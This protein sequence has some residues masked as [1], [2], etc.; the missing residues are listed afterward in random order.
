MSTAGAAGKADEVPIAALLAI[1][2][3]TRSVLSQQ[4]YV[5]LEGA[6]HRL[7]ACEDASRKF[8]VS[9]SERTRLA[10]LLKVFED[11]VKEQNL[12]IDAL[13]RQLHNP[14]SEKLTDA[15]RQ[16]LG[17]PERQK[18]PAS[19][20]PP[21]ATSP[22][23]E[24]SP[25][26][27]QESK[28][29]RKGGGR[30]PAPENLPVRIQVI[31]VPE[32]Q[33]EGMEVIRWE[34]T[35][36]IG[37]DPRRTYLLRIVRA[38]YG[39][40]Q[41]T[42]PPIVAPLPP[43]VIPRAGVTVGFIVHILMSRFVDHLPYYRQVQIDERSGVSIGRNTRCRYAMHAA[44]LLLTIYEQ[45]KELVR[46]GVY[47]HIDEAFTKLLDATRPGKARDAY[48]WGFYAPYEQAMVMEFS[49]S[50]SADVLRGF[51][52]EDWSGVAH[53]DGALMYPAAFKD[54]PGIIHIECMN[55]FRR[56]VLAAV[57]V[58]QKEALP[59][60]QDIIELYAIEAEATERNLTPTQRGLL[61]HAKAKPVLKRLQRKLL[62]LSK[63]EK[64]G[65]KPL[66]GKLGTAVNYGVSRWEHL[67]FYAKVDK[68][69]VSTDQNP[70]ER[71]WRPQKV[72][73]RNYLFI[74]SPKAGWY[75][76]VIYTIVSTCRLVGVE[77]EEYLMWV[78]PKL[79]AA[80]TQSAQ[81]L[82][83]HD[84]KKLKDAE[85]EAARQKPPPRSHPVCNARPPGG[86]WRSRKSHRKRDGI[87]LAA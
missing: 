84:F 42:R 25:A 60:L 6:I 80:T 59:L 13:Q 44:V 51:L 55:H 83:P 70:I 43:Q 21:A 78:L 3:L 28:K 49:T 82:L 33:R 5:L 79:A 39:S 66:L 81:G 75:S 11:T 38:V 18:A 72:G 54:R 63:R 73:L 19:T 64:Q 9:E 10:G 52:G 85:A 65:G 23:P 32:D 48:V 47:L 20:Q 46:S 15:K 67:A 50:R 26:S 77:P 68:G 45:L 7:A 76:A 41:R 24:S 87:P 69:Y 61:R 4:Q 14:K 40:P 27:A 12:K 22:A 29:E 30:R 36:Q 34:V 37:I 71:L 35:N 8:A 53:T 56:Y 16:Q 74:G 86:H 31:D 62:Q 1:V 2:E 58:G 17:L 57:E